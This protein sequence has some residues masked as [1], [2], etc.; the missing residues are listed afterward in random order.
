MAVYVYKARDIDGK[1]LTGI[2]EA[3]NKESVVK[4]LLKKGYFVTGVQPRI[5]S[6][7][8][9][10]LV[11]PWRA[12]VRLR[13]IV[14]FTRQFSSMIKAG[15]P[16]NRTLQVLQQQTSS[17][18][19]QDIVFQVQKDI[20]RGLPLYLALTKHP[21]AFSPLYVE[22]IKTGEMGGML[23]QILNKLAITTQKELDIRGKIRAAILYPIMV[24]LIA[25]G[26]VV[27]LVVIVLPGL[28]N[29][30]V[31]TGISL[32]LP[33]QILLSV[34]GVA[35][36]AY[37][38]LIG[39]M[40]GL[41]IFGKWFRRT[42]SGGKL[43]DQVILK[44]PVF[45]KLFS[46]AATA[47][48]ASAFSALMSSGVPVLQAME[49]VEGTVTNRVFS[50]ALANVRQSITEG[51]NITFP[52][53]SVGL[54]PPMVIQMISV[55]EETGNLDTMLA[56]V[57]E[58]CENDVNITVTT[59]IPLIEPLLILIVAIIVGFIVLS[60]VLPMLEIMYAAG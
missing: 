5:T 48:F 32:P 3:E 47:R 26:V 7:P 14:I 22:M 37:W 20:N 19:L 59:L 57:A 38:L 58:Y 13:D 40:V 56:H 1:L 46:Q 12:K 23:E 45:G 33:T 54:F 53:A 2:L 10:N 42:P 51:G 49:I 25:L 29:S 6:G 28:V 55:G 34:V 17:R 36:S 18:S 39:G 8:R 9:I 43:I 50:A 24:V 4:L 27:F 41:F 16:L 60:V 31:Q 11:L 21:A 35:R 44:I 30:L 15:I 52:L